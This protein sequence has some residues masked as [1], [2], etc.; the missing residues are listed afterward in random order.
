MASQIYPSTNLDGD[1]VLQHVYDEG[2]QTLRTNATA[3]V[4]PGSFDVDIDAATGDNIAISDGVNTAEVTSNSELKVHDENA[5]PPGVPTI[6]NVS[7]PGAGNEY[8]YTYPAD[9]KKIYIKARKG[10][11]KIAYIAGQTS[12]N[13]I[14]IPK[15]CSYSLDGVKTG[16]TV[17]LQ[18]DTSSDVI[19]VHTWK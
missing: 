11:L 19:E 16:V 8:N 18:S 1:Q 9:T 10:T 17:Y 2:T 4:L 3:T 14:L 13:Y 5:V 6:A 15:G 7:A 12:T